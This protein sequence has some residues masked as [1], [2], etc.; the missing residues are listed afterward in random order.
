M[1]LITIR[2]W[3]NNMQFPN[4]IVLLPKQFLWPITPIRWKHTPRGLYWG[5]GSFLMLGIGCDTDRVLYRRHR[6]AV[7]MMDRNHWLL[8]FEPSY[9]GFV[10]HPWYVWWVHML[11]RQH[12]D[13]VQPLNHG[14][15]TYIGRYIGV[16]MTI[17]YF[18][19]NRGS[20]PTGQYDFSTLLGRKM[21]FFKN[22]KWTHNL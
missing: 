14:K 9:H 20:G 7:I 22:W 19:Q 5:I 10:M 3:V 21:K 18:D 12:R 1:R 11:P 13:S 15:R 6:H 8:T 16:N 2:D 17:S 4:K